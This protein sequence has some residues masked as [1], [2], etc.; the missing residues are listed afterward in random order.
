MSARIAQAVALAYLWRRK[1]K[2]EPSPVAATPDREPRPVPPPSLEDAHRET[3]ALDLIDDE[4]EPLPE[5]ET[6]AE[7]K[8]RCRSCGYIKDSGNCLFACGGDES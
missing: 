8:P 7:P 5:H 4:D 1:R 2:A 6:V 3:D